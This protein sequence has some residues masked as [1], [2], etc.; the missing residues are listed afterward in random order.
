MSTTTPKWKRGTKFVEQYSD[1]GAG[2]AFLVN[3]LLPPT[4]EPGAFEALKNEVQW[5]TMYHHG[6]EVPRLVAVEGDIQSDGWYAI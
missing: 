3:N 6:G 2:D 4:V 1:L 5:K